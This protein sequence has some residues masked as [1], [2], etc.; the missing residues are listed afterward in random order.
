MTSPVAQVLRAGVHAYRWTL[1]PVLGCNCRYEP[2]C[3]AYALA[4]LAGHGALRG[5]WLAG[6]RIL[7]CNPWHPGGYDPVPE[8]PVRHPVQHPMQ[9]PV[10][11]APAAA[12]KG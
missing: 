1:K 8:P 2:S 11:G 7:R 12:P 10:S 9:H 5:S 4:A 6:R 3:S